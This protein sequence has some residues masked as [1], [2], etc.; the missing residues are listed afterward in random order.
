MGGE[1]DSD[2]WTR[3]VGGGWWMVVAGGTRWSGERR[4]QSVGFR[5][6]PQSVPYRAYLTLLDWAGK[7]GAANA[8]PWVAA[9]RDR[10]KLV[11]GAGAMHPP[12]L[13]L[14][15]SGSLAATEEGVPLSKWVIVPLIGP[16]LAQPAAR[17]GQSRLAVNVGATTPL[18]I[19]RWPFLPPPPVQ[20]KEEKAQPHVFNARFLAVNGSARRSS[21]SFHRLCPL[22]CD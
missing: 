13:V 20:A 4:G 12:S 19:A 15:L 7:G 14:L 1:A 11:R 16:P 21:H 9:G 22:C 6:V 8:G 10:P 3:M 18:A 2:S 5:Y 17:H